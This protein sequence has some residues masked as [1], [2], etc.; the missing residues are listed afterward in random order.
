MLFSNMGMIDRW[1]RIFM[2]FALMSQAFF[3]FMNPLF[4]FGFFFALMGVSGW[5]PIFSLVNWTSM[6]K[7]EI[8][9]QLSRYKQEEADFLTERS[10]NSTT[11]SKAS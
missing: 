10:F 9:D 11:E 4:L 1:S 7:K 2:G 6:S 8:H 5:C 3:G